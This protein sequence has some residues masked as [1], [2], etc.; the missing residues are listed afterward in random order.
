MVI[1]SYREIG[2]E[3]DCV[4]EG[5]LGRIGV[6]L[7]IVNF[8]AAP[9]GIPPA[10]L[11]VGVVTVFLLIGIFEGETSSKNKKTIRI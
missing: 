4:P 10:V 1:F 9:L 7:D 2:V 5:V 11:L 3:G 8:L 6:P